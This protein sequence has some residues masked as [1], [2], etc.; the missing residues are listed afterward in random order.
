[1]AE[2]MGIDEF[3]TAVQA[4][5]KPLKGQI[6]Q[7]YVQEK[8]T[9]AVS[10]GGPRDIVVV[11]DDEVCAIMQNI[12]RQVGLLEKDFEPDNAGEKLWKG[13]TIVHG[14]KLWVVSFDGP[15]ENEIQEFEVTN[16]CVVTGLNWQQSYRAI[17]N[18][19]VASN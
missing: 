16:I 10:T 13:I 4:I 3:D 7:G 9:P 14:T 15:D 6:F 8:N 11:Q 12:V 18:I 1:M 2:A 17:V 19:T 5:Y